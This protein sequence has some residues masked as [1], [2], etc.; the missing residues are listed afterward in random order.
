[1][2]KAVFDEIKAGLDDAIAYQASD[3]M[4]RRKVTVDVKQVR[5]ATR[6]TQESFARTYRLPV[7]T[8]RDWEQ[9]RR[10]P[11]SGSMTLLRMIGAA[12]DD[13]EAILARVAP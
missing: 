11:D 1:M 8:V 5:E 6:M 7:G 4:P 12:P 13:V 10:K 9:G 3:K 2:S